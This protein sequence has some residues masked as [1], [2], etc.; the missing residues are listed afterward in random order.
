ME[1]SEFLKLETKELELIAYGFTSAYETYLVP[2][3]Q[4]YDR[5]IKFVII[6]NGGMI[7]VNYTW[8]I[9]E[10]HTE[11][12]IKINY[13]KKIN[14]FKMF[15]NEGFTKFKRELINVL[16]EIFKLDYEISGL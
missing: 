2:D 12:P 9:G 5:K 1:K 16:D 10:N 13:L 6:D 11:K 7:T 15:K 8:N 14:Y 4:D 3:N